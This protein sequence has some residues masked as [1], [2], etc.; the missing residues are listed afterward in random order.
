MIFSIDTSGDDCSI[1]LVAEAA[2][3]EKSFQHERQLLERLPGYVTNLLHD[4]RITFVDISCVV[5][6]IGPGSFTGARVGVMYGKSLAY[7][8]DVP[9][10]G[11]PSFDAIA[12]TTQHQNRIVVCSSRRSEVIASAYKH[13]EMIAIAA[14]RSIADLDINEW[15]ATMFADLPFVILGDL[16][17]LVTHRVAPKARDL[18]QLAMPRIAAGDFDDVDVLVPTYVATSPGGSM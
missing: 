10:V 14:P 5:C 15:A 2:V 12:F 3:Y 16:E 6:G 8:L 11:I 4:A 18:T 7:A 9:V 1:A 17:R 13:G